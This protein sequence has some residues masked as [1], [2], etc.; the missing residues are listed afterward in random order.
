M[1][2]KPSSK[3]PIG[4]VS[5]LPS[6]NKSSK[7]HKRPLNRGQVL[8]RGGTPLSS[9]QPIIYVG[10]QSPCMGIVN[11]VRRALDKTPSS[12]STKGLPLAARMAALNSPASSD[13]P[14]DEVLVR[15]TGRAMAPALHLAAWFGKQNEYVVSVR[16]MCLETVDDVVADEDGADAEGGFAA[17]EESRTRM[18]NCLEVGIGRR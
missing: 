1:D 11:K 18:L 15:A 17:E 16:T 6:L 4:Q 2:K 3:L 12:R 8:N 9:K 10:T 5:K 14:E 13:R 7:I